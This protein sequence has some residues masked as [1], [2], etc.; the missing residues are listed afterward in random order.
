MFLM[1]LYKARTLVPDMIVTDIM[2]PEM[3]G[4]ELCRRVRSDELLSHIPVIMVT[5]KVTHEDRMRG[6]E[7]GADAWLEKPLDCHFCPNM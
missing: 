1:L 4:Y 7:A 3:D 2:M 5:A 6:L